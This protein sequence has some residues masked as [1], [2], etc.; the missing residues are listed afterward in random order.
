M[1]CLFRSLLFV[2]LMAVPPLQASAQAPSTS[3]QMQTPQIVV[4]ASGE[5]H[6]K[7]DRAEIAFSVETRAQTAAAAAAEN[8]RRQKS[9]MDALKAQIGK[10]DALSTVGYNVM[11]D[12]RYDGNERRILGYVARNTVVLETR[13]LDRVGAFIDTAL[14]AGANVV[15]GLS[16]SYSAADDAR[17]QALADALANARADAEA[18]ARAAGGALGALLEVSVGGS[19]NPPVPMMEMARAAAGQTPIEPGEQSVRAFVTVR[20][21]FNAGT[22]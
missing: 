4:S 3:P 20:W 1:R 19:A 6:V 17:R 12:E 22:R 9:V 14:A 8:A 7:P 10:E 16:F 18:L 2:T 13:M 15:H 11:A 5:V 21:A